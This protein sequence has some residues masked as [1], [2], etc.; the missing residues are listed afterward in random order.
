MHLSH[1][2]RSMA[3]LGSVMVSEEFGAG[4]PAALFL[5]KAGRELS[6]KD[7]DKKVYK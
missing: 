7:V 2:S 6:T 3:K 4:N 5:T 1:H